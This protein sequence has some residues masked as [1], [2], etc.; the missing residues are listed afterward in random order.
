MIRR[1]ST[2]HLVSLIMSEI[3]TANQPGTDRNEVI[4]PPTLWSALDNFEQ[5]DLYKVA[6][7]SNVSIKVIGRTVGL[8]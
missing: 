7:E 3:N 6:Q 4:V 8:S 1:I 2:A 5:L